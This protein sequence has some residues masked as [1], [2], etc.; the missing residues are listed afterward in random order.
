M[1]QSRILFL[2][3]IAA[4]EGIHHICSRFPHLKLIT[5]EI[6]DCVDPDTFHVL[7]GVPRGVVGEGLYPRA[8]AGICAHVRWRLN[9]TQGDVGGTERERE[10]QRSSACVFFFGGRGGGAENTVLAA[11]LPEPCCCSACSRQ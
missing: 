2:T 3:L 4:P 10:Q 8:H 1:A 9:Q 11:M 5:T 7:P 6:D